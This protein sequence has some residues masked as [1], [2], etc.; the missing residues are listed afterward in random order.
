MTGRRGER[1]GWTLGWLGG[2]LWVALLSALFLAQER[3]ANGLLGSLLAAAAVG[4]VVA[5]SPWRHPS[6]PYWKL[7]LPIYAHFLGCAGWAIW[8][9]GGPRAIGLEWWN[10]AWMAPMLLPIGTISRRRWTDGEVSVD[11]L[12]DPPARPST[13]AAGR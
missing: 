1:L 4:L 7:M 12:A 9:Y 3:V 6:T 2:F 8:S 13:R 10:A 11:P 5:L